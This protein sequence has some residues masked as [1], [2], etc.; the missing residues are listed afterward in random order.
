M[1]IRLILPALYLSVAA[2]VW[3]DFVGTPP[4]GLANI[5]LF[6][7]TLPVTVVGL[8]MTEL[9][10]GGGSFMLLPNG[11]G[12]FGSHALYYWPSVGLIALLLYLIAGFFVRSKE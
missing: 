11:F 12:Y 8:L 7:V 4:D 1:K 9:W 2:Y 5:G 3:V 10:G 6:L